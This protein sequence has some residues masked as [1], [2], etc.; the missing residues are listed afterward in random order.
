MNREAIS[1]AQSQIDTLLA[2]SPFQVGES[3]AN[4]RRV[5]FVPPLGIVF[6]IGSDGQMVKVLS[7][8]SISR[9]TA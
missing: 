5:A 1:A 3:R 7:V 4:G 8:W 9:R 6:S 2:G